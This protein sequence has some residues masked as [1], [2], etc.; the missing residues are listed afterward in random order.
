MRIHPWSPPVPAVLV[1]LLVVLSSTGC[2]TAKSAPGAGGTAGNT[3]LDYYPLLPGWGWAY[4]VESEG[5]K[6]LALYSVA[7]VRD[8]VA[9]INSGDMRMEYLVRPDGIV[10]REDGLPGDYL[11]KLP[12]SAGTAWAITGGGATVTEVEQTVVM[13]SGSYHGCAMVEEARSEPSRVTRTTYCK[14]IGPVRMEMRVY[15]PRRLDFETMVSATLRGVTSP[16]NTA[17]AD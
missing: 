17:R 6:V 14:G 5:R 10:R 4:D 13:P 1:L 11:V 9:V 16:E 15:N 2:A 8:N 12:M 3:A 7:E